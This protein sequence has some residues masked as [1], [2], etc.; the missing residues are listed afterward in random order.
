MDLEQLVDA[1]RRDQPSARRQLGVELY[2]IILPVFRGR[3]DEVDVEDLVND[4][5]GVVL[6]DLGKYENRGPGSFRAWV[7][8]IARNRRLAFAKD[9]GKAL[10]RHQEP[11]EFEL[12]PTL[13]PGPRE[14][15]HW[16][17][18]L[19]AVRDAWELIDP[20]FRAALEHLVAGGDPV[21]LAEQEGVKPHTIR[22]RA[23]RALA[24]LRG[25]VRRRWET[26]GRFLTT[27]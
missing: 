1:Y 15:V 6:R 12:M 16:R 13:E 19:M 3:F 7:R 14:R 27:P 26:S 4:T 17:E 2:R 5:V 23:S 24:A 9:Q 18:R 22:T 11:D 10:R 25:V 8:T 21:E 20:V